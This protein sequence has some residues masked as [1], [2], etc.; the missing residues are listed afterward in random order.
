MPEV[1]TKYNQYKLYKSIEFISAIVN[2][3]CKRIRAVGV[4]VFTLAF[5]F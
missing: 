2:N 3:I 4:Q 1:A 5:S